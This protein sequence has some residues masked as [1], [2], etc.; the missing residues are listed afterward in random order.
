MCSPPL[1]GTTRPLSD[2][3][4]PLSSF[5]GSSHVLLLAGADSPWPRTWGP[6]ILGL[7]LRQATAIPLL[8]SAGGPLCAV[9]GLWPP[10][11][12]APF[13]VTAVQPLHEL[14]GDRG[15]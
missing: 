9:W 2:G 5:S 11:P 14:P 10:Q 3:P 6:W 12:P 8:C 13:S 15:L 1:A 7:R 4:G